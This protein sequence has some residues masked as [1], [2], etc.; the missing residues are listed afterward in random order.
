M[1]LKLIGKQSIRIKAIFHT[2]Q[3]ARTQM[4]IERKEAAMKESKQI[5]VRAQPVCRTCK[6]CANTGR[7]AGKYSAAPGYGRKHYS[8]ENPDV[9][10]L[11]DYI[12]G[13]KQPGFIG[14]G[15]TTYESPLT[16]KTTPRW[17][18]LKVISHI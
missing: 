10:S 4:R 11:P 9:K 2:L 6:Y 13:Y 7:Q 16:M 14:F 15:D 8:C 18:P 12:F 17:C 3:P 1:G 5:R